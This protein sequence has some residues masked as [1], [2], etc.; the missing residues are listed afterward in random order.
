MVV[1]LL[2]FPLTVVALAQY[3]Y[4]LA[5][6]L[7]HFRPSSP[8]AWTSLDYA[9][10]IVYWVIC[11]LWMLFENNFL[12]FLADYM[13]FFPEVKACFFLWLSHPTYRGAAYL[14]YGHGKAIHKVCDEQLY[15]KFIGCIDKVKVPDALR[16]PEGEAA[17]SDK[18]E[19][20]SKFLREEA[21]K[22]SGKAD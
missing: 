13:P 10:W 7:D 9:Q 22:D 21:S 11:S 6:I 5:Q 18:K 4:P 1:S 2:P 17:A 8:T 12:W 16:T 20:V 14:W 15:A 19:V 3:G